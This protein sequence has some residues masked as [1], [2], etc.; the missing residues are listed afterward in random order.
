MRCFSACGEKVG[1]RGPLPLGLERQTSPLTRIAELVIGP[2]T[3]G[4]IR[5]QS[6]LS[7]HSGERL[8]SHTEL[9][10]S[11]TTLVPTAVRS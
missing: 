2:A 8:T 10:A 5:W 6:D 9:F 1:M 7:L 4:P 3:S 11:T